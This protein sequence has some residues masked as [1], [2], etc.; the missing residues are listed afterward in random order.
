MVRCDE[1]LFHGFP[2]RP[3]NGSVS[4]R[5]LLVTAVEDNVFASSFPQPF[6]SRRRRRVD[7]VDV[8]IR[9]EVRD[10]LCLNFSGPQ[11]I[12]CSHKNQV[13]TVKLNENRR[14]R[15]GQ[16]PLYFLTTFKT[17]SVG[18]DLGLEVSVQCLSH[19]KYSVV[20]PTSF[21]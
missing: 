12:V 21:R 1:N 14:G 6:E 9:R 5:C 17:S 3:E 7:V 18:V 8:K 11:L 4:F 10:R 16:K 15:T 19:E 13:R 20:L 2:S